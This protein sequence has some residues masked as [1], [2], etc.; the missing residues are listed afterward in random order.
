LQGGGRFASLQPSRL[1]TSG[2]ATPD[3]VFAPDA[4]P[5]ID[6]L[7]RHTDRRAL[8]AMID[9]RSRGPGR[10]E[11]DVGRFPPTRE[12]ADAS[13]RIPFWR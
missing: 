6:A 13:F 3:D 4:A 2:M 9:V 7:P 1:R 10:H 12:P 8:I 5:A 11:L